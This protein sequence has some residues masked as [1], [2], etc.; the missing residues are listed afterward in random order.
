MHAWPVTNRK[1]IGFDMLKSKFETLIKCMPQAVE[2][3]TGKLLLGVCTFEV[4]ALW[5]LLV[6]YISCSNGKEVLLM[7]WHQ[8]FHADKQTVSALHVSKPNK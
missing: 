3:L 1:Q 5:L 2:H 8:T 6:T 4:T 7:H